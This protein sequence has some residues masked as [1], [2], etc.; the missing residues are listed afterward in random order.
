MEDQVL[1]IYQKE[2]CVCRCVG[3]LFKLQDTHP[4]CG[5]RVWSPIWAHTQMSSAF[6]IDFVVWQDVYKSMTSIGTSSGTTHSNGQGVWAR[7]KGQTGCLEVRRVPFS[8]TWARSC[9]RLAILQLLPQPAF[10]FSPLEKRL[11]LEARPFPIAS[12]REG[13]LWDKARAEI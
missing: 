5:G 8:L 11:T 3:S 12:F 4:P 6:G 7:L 2:M 9:A 13:E 10:A 1:N